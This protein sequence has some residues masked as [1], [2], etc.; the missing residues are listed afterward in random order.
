MY[1]R[2]ARGSKFRERGFAV[3]HPRA[4][5]RGINRCSP[6][7]GFRVHNRG[8]E[9]ARQVQTISREAVTCV[10]LDVYSVHRRGQISRGY[11]PAVWLAVAR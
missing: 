2:V 1:A 3:P 10:D 5:Y 4:R 7:G 8:R 9:A 11:L 6:R